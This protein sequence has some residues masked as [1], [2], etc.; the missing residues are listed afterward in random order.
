[1][2]SENRPWGDGGDGG[3]TTEIKL[4]PLEFTGNES[5]ALTGASCISRLPQ[6]K[7]SRMSPAKEV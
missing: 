7:T 3:T 1:M 5:T 2:S 6:A 4:F